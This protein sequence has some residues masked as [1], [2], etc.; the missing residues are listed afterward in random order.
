MWKLQMQWVG[1]L[2]GFF[3]QK[4]NLTFTHLEFAN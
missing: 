3:F 2:E 4:I 1:L